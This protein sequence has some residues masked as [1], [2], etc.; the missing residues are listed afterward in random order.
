MKKISTVLIALALT[1]CGQQSDVT[2]APPSPL[3]EATSSA[4]TSSYSRQ[5]SGQP[6]DLIVTHDLHLP[7][8]I[9]GTRFVL[10]D[11]LVEWIALPT[12]REACSAYVGR[13]AD[14]R[15]I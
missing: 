4:S 13:S 8:L 14:T 15:M 5:E 3:P 9:I 1:A 10:R 6:R 12:D 11:C 7:K 2:D